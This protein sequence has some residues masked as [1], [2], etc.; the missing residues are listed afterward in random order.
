MGHNVIAHPA[1]S[2]NKKFWDGNRYDPSEVPMED[3]LLWCRAI[4]SGYK[5]Y[6][7]DDSL[8]NYR[9]HENQ[10]TGNNLEK[11]HELKGMENL[12]YSNGPQ[13]SSNPPDLKTLRNIKYDF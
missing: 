9:L 11:H 4:E 2:F 8:L 13:P 7:H 10:I 12:H 1:V 3:L 5:F 6:I